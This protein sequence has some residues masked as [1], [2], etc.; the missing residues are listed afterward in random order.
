VHQVR[1]S[2]KPEGGDKVE[3]N[4]RKLRGIIVEKNTTQAL[5]AKQAGMTRSTFYRKM[6][7]GGNEF[8]AGEIRCIK[9]ILELTLD[10]IDAIFLS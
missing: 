5:V 8:T 1:N 3:K 4:M 9:E 7:S 10:Q 2:T 6:K